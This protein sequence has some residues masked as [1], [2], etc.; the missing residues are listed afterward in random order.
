MED[1]RRR[2]RTNGD[3][4]T[5][6]AAAVFVAS[7]AWLGVASSRGGSAATVALQASLTLSGFAGCARMWH[8]SGT[9]ALVTIVAVGFV[10]R[11][12]LVPWPPLQSNDLY[13]YLWDGRLLLHGI[14]P[15]VV[16]P[17]APQ[18]AGLRAADALYARIDWRAVPTLYPPL[19]L[20]L[21]A[22]GAAFVHGFTPALVPLKLV[23]L[24]GDLLTLGLVAAS[25][26]AR[27]LPL[28]RL[29]LY[30]WS[31]LAVVE[32]GLNGHEEGW[33]IASLVAATLALGTQ[34]PRAAAVALAAAVLT[35]LY[36]AAFVP[37]L[38]ARRTLWR[39]TLLAVALVAAAY[40]PFVLWNRDVLGFLHTF[41]YGYHFND[42]LHRI[43]GT[44][45]SAALFATALAV[46]ALARSRGAGAVGVVLG[47][48]IAYLLLSPNVYPWYL[49]VFPALLPL[50]RTP[51][52]GPL[53][54]LGFALLAWTAL[55]PLAYISPWAT[56]VD[57]A[58]DVA[59]HVL[60]YAPLA[61]ALGWYA[62]RDGRR[63]MTLLAG[64]LAVSG[65]DLRLGSHAAAAP[66]ASGD[67]A[68][69]AAV[70]AAR[71]ALC[72]TPTSTSFVGP[73]LTHVAARRSPANLTEHVATAVPGHASFSP[74]TV[75]ALVAY[76]RQ[77]N[78]R[79]QT[80]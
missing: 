59:A 78:E 48:E 13:R 57:S 35:K 23:L 19:D 72:H 34:R 66:V 17:D 21:Y 29:A 7:A 71:C 70:Y 31:P 65:C 68:R 6:V 14:D 39:W 52:S 2:F 69:G 15:Y 24:A 50:V 18:L 58:P 12:V 28:G 41:A 47:L 44:T 33:A 77:L 16:P 32:F 55:A 67:V 79:S 30:A 37:V 56:P 45:G 49:A 80:K 53:R 74:A 75:A 20:A 73:D 42:S 3:A 40:A 76:L 26:R 63:A 4:L 38:F 62:F 25:L 1:R 10:A 27:G 5:F 36:P 61:L 22:L 11:A 46:A 60:E 51:F 43:A 8:R 54:P 9:R 64:A